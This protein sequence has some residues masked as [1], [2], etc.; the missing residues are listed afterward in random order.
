MFSALRVILC[1][2][3]ISYDVA[4]EFLA[5]LDAS[6][7]PALLAN[8][9]TVYAVYQKPHE[10]LFVPS[11]WLMAEM[12]VRG[13]LIYGVRKSLVTQSECSHPNYEELLGACGA[14]PKVLSRM[15]E[16]LAFMKLVT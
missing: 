2:D 11:G 15:Q 1:E 4:K 14:E 12:C 16:L 10:V 5:N 9:C 6:G 13:V 3:K 7:L 8:G